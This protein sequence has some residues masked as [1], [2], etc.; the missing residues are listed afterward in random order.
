LASACTSSEKVTPVD[1]TVE[2]YRKRKRFLCCNCGCVEKVE[3]RCE[4]HVS[5][6]AVRGSGEVMKEEKWRNSR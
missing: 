4:K 3:T 6:L 1:V 5:E 2:E